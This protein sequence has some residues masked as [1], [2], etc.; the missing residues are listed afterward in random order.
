MTMSDKKSIYVQSASFD[1]NSKQTKEDIERIE[2]EMLASMFRNM[3]FQ[4]ETRQDW[5]PSENNIIEL[6]YESEKWDYRFV[7]KL[8][9]VDGQDA[10]ESTQEKSG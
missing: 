7:L 3:A 2:R 4:I 1:F 8:T 10:G 9:R 5:S 6:C